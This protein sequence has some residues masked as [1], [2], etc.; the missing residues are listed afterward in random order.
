M[1]IVSWFNKAYPDLHK[2]V[3]C[4]SK[5]DWRHHALLCSQTL[6]RTQQFALGMHKL[7]NEFFIYFE[8]NHSLSRSVRRL[9]YF[10]VIS[11]YHWFHFCTLFLSCIIFTWN[12]ILS[13][14]V[15]FF[16]L[17]IYYTKNICCRLNMR[18]LSY[19]RLHVLVADI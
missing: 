2:R 12:E 1:K 13:S 6:S 3:F 8:N 17:R 11:C 5:I 14:L 4:A 9:H 18:F 16:F 15:H 19:A 7:F 10:H